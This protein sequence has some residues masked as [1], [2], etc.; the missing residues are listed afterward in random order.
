MI[1]LTLQNGQNNRKMSAIRQ[2]GHANGGRTLALNVTHGVAFLHSSRNM[3]T[4]WFLVGT[5]FNRL[6]TLV[7]STATLSTFWS[8]IVPRGFCFYIENVEY[9][10][11]KLFFKH[12]IM[13]YNDFKSRI[14]GWGLFCKKTLNRNIANTKDV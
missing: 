1:G 9:A 2:C 14:H 10:H 3:S 6:N 5:I 11:R 4:Q 12:W 13:D 7:C 8:V